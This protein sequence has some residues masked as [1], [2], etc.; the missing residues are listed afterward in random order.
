MIS[1]SYVSIA[2]EVHILPRTI[3]LHSKA[4]A[5]VVTV[6]MQAMWVSSEKGF[7]HTY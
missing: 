3:M 4:M 6:I 5:I 2:K 7:K 1:I